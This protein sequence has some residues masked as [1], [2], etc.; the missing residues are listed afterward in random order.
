MLR[1]LSIIMAAGCAALA[2]TLPAA[3]ADNYPSRPIRVIVPQSAGGS[4]D[5]AARIVTDRL[6]DALKQ[7]FV[8]DNRPGAGSLN[9]T[10]LVAKAAPDGYT[11]LAIAASFTI[12]PA[13]QSKLPFDPVRDFTPITQFA[14]LPHILVVNP[15]VPAKSVKE[16]V[17]LLKAKPGE[18]TCA[19]SGVGTS[20]HLATELF[21][22]MSGTKMLLVPYKG[23]SP[24]MTALLGGQVQ[25]NFSASSTSL[26]HIRAGK[27]R[28]LAVTGAK[29]STAAPELPTMAEA[30]VNGYQHASW[31]GMLAPAKTPQAIIDRLY[32]ESVKIINRD[33]VKKLFL[34]S[35]MEAEGNTPKEFA[36]GIRE[37]VDKWK[38][39][40]KVAGIKA[41]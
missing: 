38:K 41:Q 15:T 4:T 29:R 7:N 24:A 23:G 33:D 26:P 18:I 3:A 6:T 31:V 2:G 20:T 10:D 8:V 39:L 17:A 19:F 28:A 22:Y 13:M 1:H 14:D 5:V 11:L 40:V 12:T 32:A 27:L 35:G 37:E 30:G 21:Q 16:L 25:V 9:G 34:R 36:A